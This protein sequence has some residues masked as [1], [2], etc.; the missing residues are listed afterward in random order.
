[1]KR[2]KQVRNSFPNIQKKFQ[3][4]FGKLAPCTSAM[5]AMAAKDVW[6][7]IPSKLQLAYKHPL[8]ER[9]LTLLPSPH[10][11]DDGIIGNKISET[12]C[13]L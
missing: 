9:K 10:G 2:F 1:V 6:K 13:F 7:S 12:Y 8:T 3:E 5:K 4:R 11:E